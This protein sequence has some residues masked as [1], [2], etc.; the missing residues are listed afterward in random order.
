MSLSGCESPRMVFPDIDYGI[1]IVSSDM[2]V[3]NSDSRDSL[4]LVFPGDRI[5]SADSLIQLYTQDKELSFSLKKT[6]NLFMTRQINTGNQT[7]IKLT[8]KFFIL[9]QGGSIGLKRIST[10]LEFSDE[11]V[12]TILWDKK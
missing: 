4:S 7:I 9:K 10:D 2:P 3:Y 12:K 5:K 6:I 8:D 1:I 11:T